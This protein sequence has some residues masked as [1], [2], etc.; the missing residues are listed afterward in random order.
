M[1]SLPHGN[2]S[3]APAFS[4][5]NQP[6]QAEQVSTLTTY[7]TGKRMWLLKKIFIFACIFLAVKEKEKSA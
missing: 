1:S 5:Q 6:K 4:K 2:A 3:A 7:G